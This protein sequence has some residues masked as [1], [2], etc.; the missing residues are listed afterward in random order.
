MSRPLYHTEVIP[1]N[2]GNSGLWYD[3]F[4]DKWQND[5]SGLGEDGKKAWISTVTNRPCGNTTQLEQATHR[6]TK[7]LEH[8]QQAPLFYRLES[9]F[10]T[11]LGR[12]HPVENGFAW[13]QTLGTPYLPGSSVKGLV[14]AWAERWAE[15]KSPIEDIRRIFGPSADDLREHKDLKANVGSVVFLDAVP[16]TAVQLKADVMT[17]HYGPYYQDDSGNTPPADWHSPVPVPFLVVEKDQ[18][19][20]FGIMPRRSANTEDCERVKEWL[21][22]ALEWLGAGAKTAVGYGH[23]APDEEMLQKV[24]RERKKQIREQQERKAEARRQTELEQMS[25]ILREM[26]EDGYET[27]DFI[28]TP[29]QKWLERLDKAEAEE[30]IE[31]A[32]HLKA[33]YLEHRPDQWEKPNK[34]N[35]AKIVPIQKALGKA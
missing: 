21:D 33:W 34:K 22:K 30:K 35:A 14:R 32:K 17:P 24:Q 8:H 15:P 2:E 9:D 28:G 6:M 12:E 31:I 19:F 3:K 7:L 25:P 5:W 23:F 27:G 1:K 11:G 20:L 18:T 10:V 29:I 26:H 13:H 4:C 16:T